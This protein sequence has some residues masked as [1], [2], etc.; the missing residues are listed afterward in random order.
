MA[1]VNEAVPLGGRSGC[2]RANLT[3]RPSLRNFLD[4]EILSVLGDGRETFAQ[5][6]RAADACFAPILVEVG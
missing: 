4:V 6:L 2:E 1:R 5:P 3:W